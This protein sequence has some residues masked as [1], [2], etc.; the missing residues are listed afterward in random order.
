MGWREP[1]TQDLG[2]FSGPKMFGFSAVLLLCSL[3]TPSQGFIIR[4]SAAKA[5]VNDLKGSQAKLDLQKVQSGRGKNLLGGLLGKD[6]PLDGV[7]GKNGVL[8]GLLGGDGAVGGLLGGGSLLG[9]D[10][11]LGGLLGEDGAVGGLLGED[12]VLGGLLGEDGAVGSLLGEDGV[13]GGLLGRDGAVGGLL[14]EDG[15]LGGLLGG[16]GAVG[17]LLGGDGVLG[18]LLGGDGVLDG[19]LGGDGVLGGLLDRDGVLGGL[20]GKDGVLGAL[21]GKDG[22]V[23]NLLDI[24]AGLLGKDGLLGKNGLVGSLL[25]RNGGDLAEV[26]I[27]NNTLPKISLRS[28]PGFG[29][30]VGFNTQLLVEST[31][32]PGSVLCE[33]V[34]ADA[35]MLVQDK[36]ATPQNE[37]GCRTSDIS[38]HVRPKVPLLDQPLK[39]QL[40]DALR[41]LG[42]RIVGSRLS[43]VSALLGAGTPAL[44]LGALGDLPP[45]SVLSSDAIQLELNLPAG[46]TVASAQGPLA[47]T[48][49]L[50]T[51][52]PPRLGLPQRALRVLMQP[53]LGQ[54]AFSRNIT[55]STVPDSVSLSTSA[56]VPLIPQ[57][58]QILPRSLP[59]ELRLW[60]PNEP[61]MALRDKRATATLK[62][63]ID[64]F[65]P[66][67]QSQ[68][69]LF[70]LD[71][72]VVLNV[73]PWV[74][75]GRLRV[76]VALDSI[77]V[78]RA[79]PG[80]NLLGVSPLAGWLKRVLEAAYV[81]AIN[82]ALNVSI[83]LP[84]ILNASLR[85][86]Q[87]DV[88]DADDSLH[89]A[90]LKGSCSGGA[91]AQLRG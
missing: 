23:D 61:A 89:Q 13:L 63:S 15:V 2:Q 87:V 56:L 42:C 86:A 48:L 57:L 72:D 24:L 43:A 31:S 79:P 90:A 46:D 45:F 39:H 38:V 80:L 55:G 74:S 19:L 62:A 83:P 50:A 67:L 58:A 76:S 12:G 41:E 78:T 49:L 28:L 60:V 33:Q 69:P 11:V 82:D 8:G 16:D 1:R 26:K 37:E 44:P 66:A 36:W 3:L 32:A 51:G 81:P 20:L 34:E 18:G 25:V 21:L 5:G 40:S 14:G 75:D 68:R 73:V 10:G 29:H 52:H 54:G 17:S 71:T 7:L 27:L 70:S 64:I 85:E 77:S 59:L 91:P 35:V 6:N 88:T 65:S 84:N 9:L 30:Q 4:P 53:V 22:L 47:A